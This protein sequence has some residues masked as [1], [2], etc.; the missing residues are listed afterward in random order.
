VSPSTYIVV[1]ED[2]PLIRPLLERW[3]AEAGYR[4][5]APMDGD[6]KPALVIA[7]VAD[8]NSAE[9]QILALRAY[10]APILIV[11]ARFRRGLAGSAAA[12]R[13][14]GVQR[15]LPKPFTR[16]ELLSAVRKALEGAA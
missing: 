10:A 11:S 2:D 9:A 16:R 8:P 13:R 14:L 15:V 6:S 1:L 3:L 12:A 5:S 7:N 4:V